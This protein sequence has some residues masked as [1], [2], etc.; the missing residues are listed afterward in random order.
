MA[1]QSLMTIGLPKVLWRVDMPLER[2][3]P[4]RVSSSA[5]SYTIY[6]E[7]P[8]NS[9]PMYFDENWSVYL[10]RVVRLLMAQR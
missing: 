6:H 5:L 3:C 10:F 9:L 2:P 4:A 7:P 1:A 8:L